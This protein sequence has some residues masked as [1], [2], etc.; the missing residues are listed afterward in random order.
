MRESVGQDP[1]DAWILQPLAELKRDHLGNADPT[2]W[3]AD[4]LAGLLLDVAPRKIHLDAQDRERV[5]PTLA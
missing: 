5:V 2:V 3:R 1:D 4:E